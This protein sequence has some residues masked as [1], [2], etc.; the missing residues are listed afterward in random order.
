MHGW[1]CINNA[2]VFTVRLGVITVN[3]RD[4]CTFYAGTY[5]NRGMCLMSFDCIHAS[6]YID[7]YTLRLIHMS[8]TSGH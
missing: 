6:K 5:G 8:I 2:R 3:K 1:I 7:T 4:R